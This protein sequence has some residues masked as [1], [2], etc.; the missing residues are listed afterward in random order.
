M[1]RRSATVGCPACRHS[2]E[3]PLEP[4]VDRLAGKPIDL[5]FGLPLLF[6][7]VCRGHVLWIFNREHLEALRSYVAA[8]LRERTGRTG[9]L[10]MPARLPQ[11]V[12]AARNREVVLKELERLE[13]Q[14]DTIEPT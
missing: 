14:L 2:V 5:H 1:S 7:T 13:E 3:I 6:Q 4:C 9:S 10:S 12:R 11:W 8:A